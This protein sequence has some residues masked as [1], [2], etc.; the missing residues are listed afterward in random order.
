MKKK[1]KPYIKKISKKKY[2]K[3]HIPKK[4][5]FKKKNKKNKNKKTHYTIYI[6]K[7]NYKIPK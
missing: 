5:E 2:K 6:K 3:K 1:I 7:K 4:K